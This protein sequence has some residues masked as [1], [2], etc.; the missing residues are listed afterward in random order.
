M[1]VLCVGYDW[2]CFGGWGWRRDKE[3]RA[4]KRTDQFTN[5]S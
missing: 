1:L 2:L 4:Q 3:K 5:K